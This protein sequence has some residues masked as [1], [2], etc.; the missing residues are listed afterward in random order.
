MKIKKLPDFFFEKALWKKDYTVIAGIDEVG[1][2]AFAGP[3][4]AGC[5]I[6]KKSEK[7]IQETNV[8][9]NDSKKLTS[10]QREIANIWIRENCLAYGIGSAS[11]AEINKYGIVAATNKAFRRAIKNCDKQIEFLLIDAFFV[12]RVINFPK[13]KQYSIVKGDT[14]SISIAAASIIAKVHRDKLMTELSKKST[15]SAVTVYKKYNWDKNKGYGTK[16]HQDA[17]KEHGITKLHR[18]L[19]VRKL[20]GK[21]LEGNLSR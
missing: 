15:R 10:K 17:I 3:V 20:T 19:F 1:R 2:G 7:L 6:F 13:G 9:I 5:V 11:V 14:K 16:E 21:Q 4:V 18:K 12:P 8:K